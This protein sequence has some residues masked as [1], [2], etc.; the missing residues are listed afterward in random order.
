ML[1]SCEIFKKVQFD[2][3]DNSH[4][5]CLKGQ[6]QRFFLKIWPASCCVYWPIKKS[7]QS[8]GH[9]ASKNVSIIF[10]YFLNLCNSFLLKLPAKYSWWN[11]TRCSC[12]QSLKSLNFGINLVAL[13]YLFER[14]SLRKLGTLAKYFFNQQLI[15]ENQK[16]MWSKS[17]RF[18]L[19]NQLGKCMPL[20][21]LKCLFERNSGNSQ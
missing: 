13:K 5:I 19:W 11:K 20:F 16:L 10:A 8:K 14:N 2:R 18:D 1:C 15:K 4:T 17:K 6:D 12:D 21:A 3:R 7:Q 9:N